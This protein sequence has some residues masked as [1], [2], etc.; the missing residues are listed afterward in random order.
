MTKP[1]YHTPEDDTT[2]VKNLAA[3]VINQAKTDLKRDDK[4]KVADAKTFFKGNGFKMWG[5]IMGY[6]NIEVKKMRKEILKE[7]VYERVKRVL[8]LQ[9]SKDTQKD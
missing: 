5:M 8:E 3:A 4:N 7:A 2:G 6:S 9:R 1:N